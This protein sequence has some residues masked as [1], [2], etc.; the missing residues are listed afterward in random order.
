MASWVKSQ[1]SDFSVMFI[2]IALFFMVMSEH[3]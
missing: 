3:F 1:V 2:T